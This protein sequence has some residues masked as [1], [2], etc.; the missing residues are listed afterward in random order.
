MAMESRIYTLTQMYVVNYVYKV[1]RVY[2]TKPVSIILWKVAMF[3]Q[4]HHASKMFW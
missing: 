2:L 1:L 4:P 3:R